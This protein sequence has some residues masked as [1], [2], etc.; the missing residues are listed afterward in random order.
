M[1]YYEFGAENEKKCMLI[2]GMVTTWERSFAKLIPELCKN[3]HVIAVALD[4][5]N[6]D[7]DS[8]FDSITKEARN[9]EQILIDDFD[10][11]V[12][13]VYGSS[14]GGTVVIQM[15]ANNR[16]KITKAI[17][18]G[19]Y[20]TNYDFF[21]GIASKLM[22]SLSLKLIK[23]EFAFILKMMG[24]K[25]KKD[26]EKLMYNG[27]SEESLKNCYLSSYRYCLPE[28]IVTDTELQF[29][30]GSK[31]LYPPKF[32]KKVMKLLPNMMI[33]VFEGM[34]HGEVLSDYAKLAEELN[35]YAD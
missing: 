34:G 10:S 30:Y 24:V 3:F 15:L 6:P 8:T 23:G 33:K 1:K 19:T 9:V 5:H 29:W 16:V 18:E 35:R 7:E 21:S 13:V 25:G 26:V 2:H 17:I 32:A 11:K 20:A 4:G 31:E 12:D 28:K 22:T 14:L 27:I